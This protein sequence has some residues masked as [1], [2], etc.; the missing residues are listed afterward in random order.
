MGLAALLL[1][2]GP[3]MMTPRAFSI[4]SLLP[5]VLAWDVWNWL[6]ET[7]ARL[8]AQREDARRRGYG[9]R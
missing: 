5:L 3:P 4:W 2:E 7:L 8:G 9:L 1:Q 6:E